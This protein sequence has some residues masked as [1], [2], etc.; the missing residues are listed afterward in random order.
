[1]EV[2]NW[3]G[4]EMLWLES[5]INTGLQIVID[6][7]DQDELLGEADQGNICLEHQ[8]GK[9]NPIKTKAL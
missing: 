1:M 5:Q 2:V 4:K 6:L 3:S 8:L 9:E 7:M